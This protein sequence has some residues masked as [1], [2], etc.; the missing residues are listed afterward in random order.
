[1]QRH[2]TRGMARGRAR[3][4][5]GP[6]AARMGGMRTRMVAVALLVLAGCAQ[7]FGPAGQPAASAAPRPAPDQRGIISFPSFQ[8]VVARMGETT[9]SIT[10]RLGLDGSRLAG[11]NAIDPNAPLPQGTVLTLPGGPGG[12]VQVTDPYA[13]QGVRAPAVPGM[14]GQAAPAASAA[15]PTATAGAPAGANPRQ[16]R[17]ESGETA[18]SIARKYGVSIADLASWNGLPADMTI[19]SGQMLTIPVAGATAA[20]A[21]ASAPGAG[22]PTPRPPSAATP[23]PN[24]TAAPATQAPPAADLGATRTAASSG[25]RFVMPAE[26]SIIRAYR[27]GSNDGIDIGAAAGSPVRAAASG[28]VAAITRDTAGVPIVVIRHQGELMT[29]YAG[30]GSLTVAKGDTVTAGQAIGTTRDDGTM[31]FEV[32]QG[33]ESV[34]PA[35]YL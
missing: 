16:H 5:A 14:A 34:D 17:V 3:L 4:T 1:M 22:S 27:K 2:E 13:G 35:G 25:G 18:W 21:A 11:H 8:L 7:S 12:S 24:E 19:R 26:G 29:V 30:L 9:A 15:A 20:T 23:L 33:F 32:R 6:A 10:Q 28:T 31:H